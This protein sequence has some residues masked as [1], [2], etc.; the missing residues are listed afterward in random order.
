MRRRVKLASG[1]AAVGAALALAGCGASNAN[2]T[3]SP[4]SVSDDGAKV[5]L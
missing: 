5:F 3:A 1:A 4:A 2:R